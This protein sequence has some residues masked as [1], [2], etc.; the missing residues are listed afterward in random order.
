MLTVFKDSEAFLI[1]EEGA[2]GDPVYLYTYTLTHAT[3]ESVE[4]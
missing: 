1:Y 3:R 2:F 4:M